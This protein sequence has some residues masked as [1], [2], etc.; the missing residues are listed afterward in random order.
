MG[1]ECGDVT[2]RKELLSRPLSDEEILE[3]AEIIKGNGLR[4][5]TQNLLG[6][7][8]EDPITVDWKT[9][10]LNVR[11]RPDFAWSSIFYPYPRTALGEI[12]KARGF[13]DGSFEDV[14]QTNK[15]VSLL[16]WPDPKAR[17]MVEN[18]HKLFGLAVEFPRLIPLVRRLI[19]LDPNPAFV[20]AYFL[21]YGYCWKRRIE[22]AKLTPRRA[23]DLL[24]TLHRYL[25]GVKELG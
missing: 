10:E 23:F 9:L 15:I 2:I 6:L 12:A 8:V 7:P 24:R 1:V 3:A 19:K 14:P 25:R 21:W 5:A 4:L 16:G 11:I 17:T 18:L 13:F 20:N 22:Q